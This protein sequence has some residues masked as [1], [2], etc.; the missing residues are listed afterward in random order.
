MKSIYILIICLFASPFFSKNDKLHAQKTDHEY[1]I[2]RYKLPI[3]TSATDILQD[4]YGFVWIATINGLW[5]YDGGSYKNYTKNENDPNGITNNHISCLYEDSQN[6]LWIGTYGGGLLKYNRDY[7]RFDRFIHDKSNP[8][9]LSFDE[10][11]VLFETS[12]NE[13]YVGTDGGGLNLLNRK[14]NTFKHYKHKA[15]DSTS[16][17]HNNILSLAEN[18]QGQLYIGTWIGFNIFDTKTEKF[19]RIYR[20][21]L[22]GSQSYYALEYL[23]NTLLC[24]NRG[25]IVYLD[26]TNQLKAKKNY[27]ARHIKKQNDTVSWLVHDDCIEIKNLQFQ[28]EKK[29]ALNSLFLNEKKFQ[30]SKIQ[31]SQEKNSNWVLDTSGHFFQLKKKPKIVESFLTNKNAGSIIKTEKYFWTTQGNKIHIYNKENGNLQNTIAHFSGTPYAS[32]HSGDQVWVADR[33]SLYRFSEQGTLLEEM[34]QNIF[35][36][37]ILHTATNK[38]WIGEVLGAKLYD[39][40][41]KETTTFYCN[42]DDPNGIGYFHRASVVLEDHKNDI[43]IGTSGDGLKKY[44]PKR[45]EFKHYRHVIGDASSINNNFIHKLFQDKKNNLWIGTSAGLCRLDTLS[46]TFIQYDHEIIKDKIVNSIEEDVAGNLWIGTLNGLIKFNPEQNT[47]KITNEQDGLPSNQIFNSSLR[48]NSGELV[49]SSENGFLKFDPKDIKPSKLVPP[50]Y[51]SK[52]W[53]NNELIQPQSNYLSKSIEVEKEIQLDYSDKKFEFEFQVIHYTNNQRCQYAY[54]LQGY[55]KSWIQINGTPKATYTNIPP[56]K[57]IFKVKASNED[58][59]WNDNITSIGVLIHPPFWDLLWVQILLIALLVASVA[60]TFWWFLRKER[61]RS[62]FEIEQERMIQ[63]EELAKMKLRFF[64][65]IS[66]ELRTPLTLITAPLNKFIQEKISPTP[67]VLD[68]MYRNSTSLLELINQILDF[69]KLENQPTLQIKAQNN[70]ALFQNIEHSFSY[71]SKEKKITFKLQEETTNAEIYF[72]TDIVKKI[73]TNLVSNAFKYT[74]SHGKITVNIRYSDIQKDAQ[75][76]ISKGQM[77]LEV[78]DNG[79]GIPSDLKDKI[80]ERFYQLNETIGHEYSSGIGLSL[81]SEMV[82]LHKGTIA[83]TTEE[84]QGCH[85]KVSLPIG[86]NNY[87]NDVEIKTIAIPEIK[88]ESTVILIIEDNNDIRTYLKEELSESY[89]VLEASNGKEGIQMALTTIPDIVISDIMMPETDGLQ[90]AHQLKNNELTAHI[91][92]LFLTAKVGTDNKLA[93][94]K[95]GADDYIQKPFNISEVKL[96]LKNILE[97]RKLLI[98]K[99]QQNSSKETSPKT[100]DKFLSRLN[101]SIELHLENSEFSVDQLCTELSIGRS[102]LYRKTQALTGKSIIEYI[103]SYRLIKAMHF[104]KTED[105]SIKEIAY[106]VGYNDAKYFSRTFKKEY[107]NSPTFYR[108][109]KD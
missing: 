49:F 1:E 16:V 70:T 102:Q 9:S 103:N 22:S 37:S 66:H 106:K 72:D 24:T 36:F 67:K 42:A 85:F 54:K 61:I 18:E 55:D 69:R 53:V 64:T 28:T 58:G 13:F 99:F 68:M 81:T 2:K 109:P 23:N 80:F 92:L 26:S 95:T 97:S 96:K 65:N 46:N 77:T 52:L 78:I 75:N 60:F 50:V 79:P 3:E 38:V 93:G 89:Q 7:D 104:I 43:W 62:K 15:S 47:Y 56:G 27:F 100:T 87:E 35:P 91:P 11:R 82:Q 33:K 90:F 5:K 74:P 8:K 105:F 101:D 12:K 44:L 41:T 88:T 63:F 48:L 45:K 20:T 86:Y 4:S 32:S 17:S 25:Q 14:N 39:P 59:V 10:I 34:P 57:Y 21:P 73:I 107:G 71:W 94:L 51:L 40:S 98:K 83:L 31:H 76:K 19:Q 29:I 30:L 6:T 108:K 84:G